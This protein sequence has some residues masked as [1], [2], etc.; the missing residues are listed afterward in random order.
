MQSFS[1][2]YSLNSS[3]ETLNFL[4]GILAQ[5]I[6]KDTSK[7]STIVCGERQVSVSNMDQILKTIGKRSGDEG[8]HNSLLQNC[9]KL[10]LLQA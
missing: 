2:N 9:R 6:T 5:A 4:S 1:S 7:N 8:R 3:S 10:S